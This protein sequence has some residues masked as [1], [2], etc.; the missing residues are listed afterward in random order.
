MA[1]T[2]KIQ[3]KGITSPQVW[4]R[5][6]VPEQFS[7][8]RFHDVIQVAFGWQD[9]H[10]F[11]FGEKGFDSDFVIGVPD[12]EFEE[13]NT[14]DSNKIRL[15]D[16][17]GYEGQKFT[18][19]YDFGDGWSHSIV[20]EKITDSKILKADCLAGKGECPPEDCGGPYGY[21]SL[22]KILADPKHDEY[23]SMKE[24]LGL[25]EDENWDA[26]FFDLEEARDAVKAV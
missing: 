25:D 10:L 1:F 8:H 15:E 22:K 5:I 6:I 26:K 12:P 20:L 24:W 18:Y 16:I 14:Q 11:Q 23:E 13:F 3:I 2:F 7:F 4:R 21:A 17:F 19:I 9:Y